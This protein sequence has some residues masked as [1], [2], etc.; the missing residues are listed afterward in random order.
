MNIIGTNNII[1][2]ESEPLLITIYNGEEANPN[3]VFNFFGYC[4][5][6]TIGK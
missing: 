5:V 3:I 6:L 2:V 4:R 1:T